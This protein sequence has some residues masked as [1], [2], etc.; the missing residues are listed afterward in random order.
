MHKLAFCLNLLGVVVIVG[1][2]GSTEAPPDASVDSAALSDAPMQEDAMTPVL[3][4]DAPR[5]DAGS[6][7][8]SPTEVGP[9]SVMR[10][11]DRVRRDRREIPVDVHRPEGLTDAPGVIMLSGFL[12]TS[13]R[14]RSLAARIA[15]HGFV[16]VQA[17]PPSSL[18]DANHVAMKEDVIAVLDWAVETGVLASDAAV[19]VAGHSLGGKVAAMVAEEDSR[20]RALLAIDPVNGGNPFSG[21]SEQLPDIVPE[22]VSRISVPSGLMGETVNASGGS[23]GMACAPRDQNFQTFFEAM[24]AAPWLVEWD[25]EGADHMDFL[26]DPEGCGFACT[27]C[28]AGSADPEQVVAATMTLSV[29]FFRQHLRGEDLGAFLSGASLPAGVNVRRPAGS[30]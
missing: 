25:F 20:V 26:S 12:L 1:C 23:F 27:Q 22:L 6:M 14:Y 19:G 2:S 11:E 21:Y 7:A 18:R 10:S 9:Y 24:A 13:E 4:A 3:D 16:V 28:S 30:L 17:V 5:P 29:A 15:P 8:D